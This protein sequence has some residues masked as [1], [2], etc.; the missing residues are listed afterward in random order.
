MTADN[1]CFPSLSSLRTTHSELLRRHQTQGNSSDILHTIESFINKG[2]ATGALLDDEEERWAAQ[3]FLDYWSA[4]LYRAGQEPPEATLHDFDP[5]LISTAQDQQ[6][7]YVGLRA[8]READ[9]AT[10]YGQQAVITQILQ[11]VETARLITVVGAASSGK[12]SA[13]LAGVLPKIKAR[14]LLGKQPWTYLTV[15]A[16]GQKPLESIAKLVCPNDVDRGSWTAR[17]VERLRQDSICFAEAITQ[18]SPDKPV[19]LVVDCLEDIFTLCTDITERHLFFESLLQLVQIDRLSHTVV[20]VIRAEY[21]PQLTEVSSFNRVAQRA[22]GY[23]NSPSAGELKQMILGPANLVGLKFEDG[24]VDALVQDTLREPDCL[25]LLQF[26][27]TSLWEKRELNGITWQSYYEIGQG[28]QAVIQR[29]DACFESLSLEEQAIAQQ[30]LL[31][32]VKPGSGMNL[33]KK[34]SSRRLL[35]ESLKPFQLEAVGE[36][37]APKESSTGEQYNL[38]E[39][40]FINSHF[41]TGSQQHSIQT[42]FESLLRAKLLSTF[43][44]RQP[45]LFPWETKLTT[46]PEQVDE[47]VSD[48]ASVVSF[49]RSQLPSNAVAALIPEVVLNRITEQCQRVLKVPTTLG[50]TLVKAVAPLFPEDADMLESIAEIVLVPAYRSARGSQQ[51]V[52]QLLVSTASQYNAALLEQ[53]IAISM[54]AAREIFDLSTLTLSSTQP[55]QRKE[56]MTELG[57]L[58]LEATLTDSCNLRISCTLPCGGTIC[59]KYDDVEE[60]ATR[61][62]PGDLAIEWH[63]KGRSSRYYLE[64]YLLNQSETPFLFLLNVEVV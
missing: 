19:L 30:L 29:A 40:P 9:H 10:F 21:E 16:P 45:L 26:L 50:R 12:T 36:G 24:L 6:C 54:L 62:A 55:N 17:F 32:L 53:K 51:E 46:Y 44:Q 1:Y 3:S 60:R 64:I 37:N 63:W 27:L 58:L 25:S 18:R 52:E 11:K 33:V 43:E 47:T 7:P 49:W 35:E 39:Q 38:D 22:R 13:V 57:M 59:V 48:E 5:K 2:T 4:I 28:Q 41:N 56:G 34:R 23:I 42:R 20:L 31:T 14:S 61:S 15:E 8:Y